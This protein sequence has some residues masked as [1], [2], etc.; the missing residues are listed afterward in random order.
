MLS[1]IYHTYLN[2][3]TNRAFLVGVIRR[4]TVILTIFIAVFFQK[5]IL[6]A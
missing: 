4:Y 5:N 1:P 6:V 2:S 3:K